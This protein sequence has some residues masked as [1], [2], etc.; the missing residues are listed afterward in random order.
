ML[1]MFAGEARSLTGRVFQA[2]HI[3]LFIFFRSCSVQG[4]YLIDNAAKGK[5]FAAVLVLVVMSSPHLFA[6]KH[7]QTAS[8]FLAAATRGQ[9]F[10]ALH[11]L[12]LVFLSFFLSF[13][14][15]PTYLPSLVVACVLTTIEP[16]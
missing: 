7:S 15:L 3:S 9:D 11:S 8:H 12:M 1:A 16:K 5:H 2:S 6:F 4:S 13:S 14:Y 10:E